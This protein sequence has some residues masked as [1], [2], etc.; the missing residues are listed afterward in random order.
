MKSSFTRRSRAYRGGARRPGGYT[1]VEILIVL[2]LLG[3]VL[4]IGAPQMKETKMTTESKGLSSELSEE[5]RLAR[6][7]A[8]TKQVPVG[9]IFPTTGGLK[10]SSQSC[11]IME[12][13]S[14]PQITKTVDY[15]TKYSSAAIFVGYWDL[16]TST[17]KDPTRTN[18]TAQPSTG[19]ISDTFDVTKW[20]PPAADPKAKDMAF[21][22]MPSGVVR[23]NGLPNFD[24]NFHIV[25]SRAVAYEPG[26]A[27]PTAMEEDDFLQCFLDLS[28]T[29]F[30]KLRKVCKP[31]T[32]TISPLGDISVTQGVT[33]A[34]TNSVQE[35][36]SVGGADPPAAPVFAESKP[37]NAPVIQDVIVEPAQNTAYLQAQTAPTP[38]AAGAPDGHL[39]LTVK[40]TDADGDTPCSTWSASGGT[41]SKPGEQR[42]EWV[43]SEAGGEGRWVSKTEWTPP[44]TASPGDRFTLSLKVD[45]KK[46]NGS[47][48]YPDKIIRFINGKLTYSTNLS[49]ICTINV[50]GTGQKQL[51]TT[52]YNLYPS[53]SPDGTKIAFAYAPQVTFPYQICTINADGTGQKQLTTG[54]YNNYTPVFSP[55]GKNIAYFSNIS[56]LM[57]FIMNADG[58]SQRP[59]YNTG[60]TSLDVCSI[61]F[62]PDGTKIAY[63]V[64][65]M[66]SYLQVF[67][68]NVDGSGSSQLTTDNNYHYAPSFSPD[69][70]KIVYEAAESGIGKIYIRNADGTG[71]PLRLSDPSRTSAN[72]VFSPDGSKVAYMCS[73]STQQIFITKADGTGTPIQLTTGSNIC[74]YPCFSPDGTTIAYEDLTSVKIC[75]V[76]ADGTGQAQL[77]KG[78]FSTTGRIWSK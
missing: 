30:Y 65:D 4:G 55:E 69:G 51:T 46:P 53:F 9:V 49:Q 23:T 12:G 10:A 22:F 29:V 61:A 13:E 67:I 2:L 74:N 78:A 3:L 62:S 77:T 35:V 57:L 47:V 11:Y 6:Q 19:S 40:A 39:T 15:S 44:S 31:F 56:T 50:D 20:G 58:T 33:G 42:M 60:L 66:N 28:T 76:N 8:I 63:I 26:E 34:D 25:V 14:N 41:F 71:T 38:D 17:L 64:K 21:I 37:N 24:G 45:D 54:T 1:I 5:L 48:T 70:Q 52:G 36:S 43:Q 68:V 32:I 27:L 75:V 73:P 18:T 7:K 16:D 59:L 72:A